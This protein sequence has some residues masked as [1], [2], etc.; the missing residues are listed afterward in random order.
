MGWSRLSILTGPRWRDG[1]RTR[2]P[3]SLTRSQA[4]RVSDGTRGR[5]AS[6]GNVQPKKV[7][8]CTPPAP[9]GTSRGHT[10]RH[11]RPTA[12]DTLGCG[13]GTGAEVAVQSIVW[14]GR[15][16]RQHRRLARGTQPR[17]D[18]D[19]GARS[20]AANACPRGACRPARQGRDHGDRLGEPIATPQPG[21]RPRAACQ[22]PRRGPCAPS[23]P[24][25]TDTAP[26]RSRRAPAGGEAEE[27]ADEEAPTERRGLR[28]PPLRGAR[29]PRGWPALGTSDRT[30]CTSSRPARRV[31]RA[32]T[33]AS[34]SSRRTD[35]SAAMRRFEVLPA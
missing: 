22:G 30:S 7:S 9:R 13:A 1:L 29:R 25:A 19:H 34:S 23:A 32:C 2:R 26:A 17:P 5:S 15:S 12:R 28:S 8:A 18:D 21:G 16:V 27:S 20:G 11:G 14:A 4:H 6:A 10:D 24:A 31:R 3:R 35:T 33:A